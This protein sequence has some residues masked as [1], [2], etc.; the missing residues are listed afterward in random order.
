MHKLNPVLRDGI[1]SVGGRL[2]R[3][4]MPE[5]AKHP[6][7]H[8]GSKSITAHTSRHPRKDRTWWSQ[9]CFVYFMSKVFD[10]KCKLS[11]Q[12]GSVEV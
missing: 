8:Q 4:A 10:A 2:S 9:P 5:E 3:A 6:A 7:I 1:L 12:K 11:N